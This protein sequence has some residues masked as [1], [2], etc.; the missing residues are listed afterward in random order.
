V[1][2]QHSQRSL[3][4]V[5]SDLSQLK[6]LGEAH[7]ISQAVARRVQLIETSQ[8]H[9]DWGTRQLAQ[10]L[11]RHESWVRKWQQRWQET[12]SLTDAPRSG[13]PRQFS[14]EVR[15]QVTALACSLPR[16][17]G[18]PLARWSR[19]ELARHVA[20]VPTLPTVSARTIGRWLEAEQIHPWRYHSWQHIQEPEA[21][22]V[23]AR[24]VLHLYEQA[25]SLLNQGI[26]V[27][28]TDEKTSIQAREA[29]QAPRPAIHQHPVYQSPRYHRRG[30]L[31]LM[32]ALSVADG[33]VYGQCHPRKRFVDFRS[34]LETV[35]I[36]E[37]RRRGVQTVALVLDNGS[38][39]AP[40]QLPRWIQELATMS[41][42][43]LTM[44]LYWLP[45][46]AS[47]LDQLEIWFSLLQRK[48]LQPNHFCSLDELEQAI[49][50]FIS[51][52]NQA[53]KP[54]KWSYTVEQLE[55][56]FAS[57][58]RGDVAA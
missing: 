21:F 16:S 47:W 36:A 46:N 50:N 48:L 49:H 8:K 10:A 12:Q 52:Y 29:E 37:A 57:R 41:E 7:R 25:T 23:R 32:A 34:F 11:H 31:H 43:K 39:H 26:W 44:Q 38:T 5:P 2:Y 4:P 13:A 20:T 42:R 40:K 55:H 24:P 18:V 28:C 22:L 15:A 33:L 30:A 17:H 3:L 56:K 54:I 51:H 58:L 35:I 27:V 14:P 45:T 9:P 53:A 1:S 19:V 6:L